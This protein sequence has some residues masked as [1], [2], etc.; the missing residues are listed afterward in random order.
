MQ[1]EKMLDLM[2]SDFVNSKNVRL[3]MVISY[4]LEDSN[5]IISF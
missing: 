5:Y 3:K 4:R 1:V 2:E